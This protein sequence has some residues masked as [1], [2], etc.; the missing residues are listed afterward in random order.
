M[1]L[2]FGLPW[3]PRQVSHQ[4]LLTS[5]LAPSSSTLSRWLHRLEALG[6]IEQERVGPQ[7]RVCV[8]SIRA[9]LQA[10]DVAEDF[11]ARALRLASAV[12]EEIMAQA[13]AYGRESGRI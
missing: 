4:E 10:K 1:G 7:H 13:F 9:R 6:L 5:K 3:C 2:Y 11:Y 12:E 8:D